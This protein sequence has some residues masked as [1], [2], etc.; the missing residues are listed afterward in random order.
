MFQ[1]TTSENHAASDIR[2]PLGPNENH[3]DKY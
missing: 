1:S 2:V 3:N